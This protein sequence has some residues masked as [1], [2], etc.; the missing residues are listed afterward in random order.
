LSLVV[1]V[2][3]SGAST[4]VAATATG[5]IASTPPVV[6]ETGPANGAT[7]INARSS[8]FV[9]FSQPMDS[10]SVSDHLQLS[11]AG[12]PEGGHLAFAD[13]GRTVFF[14]PIAPLSYSASCVLTIGS[15]ALAVAGQA[16]AGDV[17]STFS[18]ESPPVLTIAS[19]SPPSGPAGVKVTLT[20]KGFDPIAVLNTV[21]MG[22]TPVPIVSA[23]ATSIVTTISADAAAGDLAITVQTGSSTSDV[24]HFEVLPP[25]PDPLTL[26]TQALTRAG[27]QAISITPDGTRAYI[28]VPSTNAV[29][30]F[31]LQR[32]S[33][34]RSIPVG[35]RPQAIAILPDGSRAY[36]ANTGSNDLS[37]I[38]VDPASPTYNRALQGPGLPIKVGVGPVSLVAS[39]IGPQVLVLNSGD[40]TLSFVDADPGDATFNRVTST[41]GAGSGGHQVAITP[42]GTR[43]Y[44]ASDEGILMIDLRSR[45]V[46]TV[47]GSGT[48][49]KQVAISPDGTLLFALMNDGRLLIVDIAPGSSTFNRVV[50]TAG[51]GT[52]GKQIAVSP[53]GTLLY[54]AFHDANTIV[55]F[56]I[57]TG[58]S[59]G[60]SG[61]GVAPGAA[62]SLVSA[63]TVSV[64]QGPEGVAL[65][66]TGSLGV[67]ANAGDGTVS[68]LDGGGSLVAPQA[69]ASC[70][71]PSTP[72]VSM[73]V[74]IQRDT[75]A[76]LK[77]FRIGVR[78]SGGLTLCGAA[79][80]EG[81]Y[82]S[83]AGATDF[84]VTDL[85]GGLYTVEDSLFG[86]VC[87]ATQPVGTLFTVG[88]SGSAASATG[89][90]AITD[91]TLSGCANAPLA[92]RTGDA[93]TISID[94]AV[95]SAIAALSTHLA[96]S[97]SSSDGTIPMTVQW[98][99]PEAGAQVLVYRAPF[100]HYPGYD[101]GGSAA[102]AAPAYP[103]GTPWTRVATVTDGSSSLTD[104]PPS[105]DQWF[106]VAYV[107]DGCGNTSPVSNL[108]SGTIDYLLGDFS[109]GFATCAG[110]NRVDIADVSFLGSHYGATLGAGDPLACLDIG[111]TTTHGVDGRPLTDREINFE[112]L[113]LLAINFGRNPSVAPAAAPVAITGDTDRVEIDAPAHMR[114]GD[115][116]VATVRL[117]GGGAAH[118][119]SLR[120]GWSDGALEP[121][122]WESGGYFES[123]GG[124]V[125]SP[126]PGSLDGAVLGARAP[127]LAGDGSFATFRF[128]A[129]RDGD[130]GL[131]I[132]FVAARNAANASLPVVEGGVH[133]PALPAV[134]RL[135]PPRPNPFG[136]ALEIGFS[137]ARPGPIDLAVFA[138]D[139]RRVRTLARGAREA[140][141]YRLSWDGRDERGEPAA[142]GVYY[143]RLT[144]P[145]ARFV[146]KAVRVQ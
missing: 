38:D 61:S 120:L 146:H 16:L 129:L 145:G 72:C 47:A 68:L 138:V 75:D 4:T 34:I 111:P 82:L 109:N 96:P 94:G 54:V 12:I 104:L 44:V 91:V 116:V 137:L 57:V 15:G 108:T 63:A 33:L 32:R 107:R 92:G 123:R 67:V 102:P 39:G 42:D 9:R 128:R 119:V 136:A 133:G 53:D 71:T 134:T 81:S 43:C 10:A 113:I 118:A 122:G 139:G 37:V 125:M 40:A 130:P 127:G 141:E 46:T 85:G 126:G 88:L 30:A 59:G 23:T 90:V 55:I 124:V 112:D 121:A 24:G 143:V 100:G 51:A 115:V 28:S 52:G 56:R 80:A 17:T 36:V 35:L 50:S 69:P 84:H 1:S 2:P 132:R 79:I 99:A 98:P 20:G 31:D 101:D 64:G 142:T 18:V 45:A 93:A 89:S 140:G 114:A 11:V 60:G 3:G 41:A 65:T 6:V 73:P 13:G 66:P 110:D 19:V 117:H 74:T 5:D 77:S 106:Y 62:A 22:S 78:L 14:T 26:S 87:G 8:L 131:A 103:P 27:V 48:G 7:D 135:L 25:K 97:G 21:R 49:G 144:A 83:A 58:A 105:R 95:P 29:L 86:A 76:P 70:I